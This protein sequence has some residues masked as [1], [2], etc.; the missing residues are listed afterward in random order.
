MLQQH[1]RGASQY[2]PSWPKDFERE[3]T[4]NATL[5]ENNMLDKED[6]RTDNDRRE[7]KNAEIDQ[8]RM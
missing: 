3:V 8:V 6:C 2:Y 1:F 7:E 5:N 4:A